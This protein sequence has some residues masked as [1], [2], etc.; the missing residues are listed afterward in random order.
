MLLSD[1]AISGTSVP[2][3]IR[4]ND[5]QPDCSILYRYGGTPLKVGLLA[6]PP[7]VFKLGKDREKLHQCLE[8]D[9]KEALCF[10]RSIK[11]PTFLMTGETQLIITSRNT[12][13]PF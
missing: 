12:A 13:T 6:L 5:E 11:R 8:Q 9:F 1:A 3:F 7:H 10:T 2:A 4:N